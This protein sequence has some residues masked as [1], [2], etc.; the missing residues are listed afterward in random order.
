MRGR[1]PWEEWGR[2][3]EEWVEEE[4]TEFEREWWG[5][6]SRGMC[7][8][9]AVMACWERIVG[10]RA[11]REGTKQAARGLRKEGDGKR[12]GCMRNT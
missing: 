12:R 2:E 1:R 7:M 10:G 9:T 3:R 8:L 4:E 5:R 6:K 11:S